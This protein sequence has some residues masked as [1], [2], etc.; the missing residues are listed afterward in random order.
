I[1]AGSGWRGNTT[2]IVTHEYVDGER[3]RQVGRFRVYDSYADA[4]ADHGRLLSETPRYAS[5]MSAPD[6]HSAARAVQ[7]SGYATDPA[8][9]EKL[10]AVMEGLNSMTVAST[11]MK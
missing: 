1:K 5:V 11:T 3:V 7:A 2:D 10:I 6:A 8:Y 4:F 9:A